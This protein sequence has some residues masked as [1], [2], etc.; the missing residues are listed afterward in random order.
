MQASSGPYTNYL[1]A[2]LEMLLI[3]VLLPCHAVLPAIAASQ[4]N[5]CIIAS[6]SN[7][8]NMTSAHPYH[9]GS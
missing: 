5:H 6:I 1:T 7:S 8:Y 2:V 4:S 9:N 3:V